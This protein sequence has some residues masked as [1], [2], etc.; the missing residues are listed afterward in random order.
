MNRFVE[1]REIEC[2]VRQLKGCSGVMFTE[3]YIRPNFID[4][5]KQSLCSRHTNVTAASIRA[6]R[7]G[8]RVRSTHVDLGQYNIDGLLI[9]L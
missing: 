4:G 5:F 2:S 9:P 8:T 6:C 1:S 7:I 3:R